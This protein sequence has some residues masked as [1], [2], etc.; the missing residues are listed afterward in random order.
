MR[1]SLA[2]TTLTMVLGAASV[3][4]SDVNPARGAI[5]I[6]GGEPGV[7]YDDLQAAPGLHVILVPAGRTGRLAL[8]DPAT[9]KVTSVA[10]F[11]AAATYP[12]GHGQGTTSAVELDGKR[13][14]V[15]ATDRG[16]GALKI[17]DVRAG[18]IVA[19]VALAGGPDYVRTV[20]AA[21]E[22]WV[23][24]PARKR[25]EVLR[26]DD[27]GARLSPAGEVIVPDGPESLVVDER[28]GRAFTQSWK[29][30]TYAVDLR[31]RRVVATWKNGCRRA[32][33]LALDSTRGLLFVGCGEG[34]VTVLS[35]ATGRVLST[36][37]TGPDVDSIGYAAS[38]GHLYVPSAGTGVL[39]IFGVASDGRLTRLGDVPTAMG[40]HTVAFDP[41][42]RTLF[43]GTPDH[44]AVVVARD[45]FRSSL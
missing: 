35:V 42:T 2:A 21:R 12:G 37:S 19:S 13:G 29:T 33:G 36:A 17:V 10:G 39:E 34:R 27:S 43:V 14:L 40:A 32:R 25:I 20:A 44:G 6:P 1:A 30:D 7:G 15:V 41:P 23:T 45:V 18:A 8:I 3:A 22:V 31:V 38:L 28:A 16:S 11:S 4:R 26:A 24:E 5:A 9:R